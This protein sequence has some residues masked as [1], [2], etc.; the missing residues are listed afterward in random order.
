MP[1]RF[2]GGLQH[3]CVILRAVSILLVRV[4]I[5]AS[6]HGVVLWLVQHRWAVIDPRVSLSSDFSD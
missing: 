1:L 4:F 6:S 5:A 2:V 3:H